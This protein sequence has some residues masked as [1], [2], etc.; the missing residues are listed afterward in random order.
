MNLIAIF[1]SGATE[2]TVNGLHQ[3]DYG[4]KLEIHAQDL[5]AIVEVHF[6]CPGMDEAVVRV[7]SA[8]NGSVTVAI[9]NR[10]LEQ[11]APIAVWVFE[12]GET[13]GQTIKT[14]TLNILART[15]PQTAEAIEPEIADKYT[16]A[17][18]AMTEAVD[19][20]KNG[21]VT[22]KKAKH[23]EELQAVHLASSAD[24][25]HLV[26]STNTGKSYMVSVGGGS[27]PS[28]VFIETQRGA[29][30]LPGWSRGVLVNNGDVS[31][32][33]VDS[34]G[35]H[36]TAFYSY[37]GKVW[38]CKHDEVSKA[39]YADEVRATAQ[40]K[41]NA[42]YISE[43]GI[44]VVNAQPNILSNSPDTTGIIFINDLE[45]YKKVPLKSEKIDAVLWLCYQ[46]EGTDEEGNR[47]GSLFV[48]GADMWTLT[49]LKIATLL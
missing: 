32:M 13:Y 10:C 35:R 18:D 37:T 39:T 14:L 47:I 40:T 44:Y 43:P 46:P 22:A 6:A 25:E 31:L 38:V 45:D 3:W 12:V 48:D 27:N 49:V 19:D 2:L 21:N 7:G 29:V 34:G 4:R 20:I 17:V 26:D 8:V 41:Q 28:G 5:P 16:E 24:L 42:L 15:R 9:P 11:S 33:L 36:F 1:P 23:A 30:E